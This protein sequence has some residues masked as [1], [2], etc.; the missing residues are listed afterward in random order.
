MPGTRVCTDWEMESDSLC[1]ILKEVEVMAERKRK[2]RN[3]EPGEQVLKRLTQRAR[4]RAIE[5][6]SVLVVGSSD[7]LKA[8]LSVRM[9]SGDANIRRACQQASPLVMALGRAMLKRMKESGV[10]LD[11]LWVDRARNKA[12][13]VFHPALTGN[14]GRI[15][16]EAGLG[17]VGV[18]S[19][20]MGGVVGVAILHN[21]PVREN[22]KKVL[23]TCQNC[24]GVCVGFEWQ[25]E[26]ETSD[27]LKWASDWIC[28]SVVESG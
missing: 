24:S 15:Y 22:T 19:S 17:D 7:S 12:S 13:F 18:I 2:K 3:T 28:A 1:E 23:G 20:M 21:F 14:I 16:R 25:V 9:Q 27:D 8:L 10:D 6:H 26:S 4:E 5:E 11:S